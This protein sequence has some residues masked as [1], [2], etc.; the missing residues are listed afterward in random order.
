M[1]VLTVKTHPT[2]DLRL[3]LATAVTW[4]SWCVNLQNITLTV[5]HFMN[6]TCTERFE[7]SDTDIAVKFKTFFSDPTK[8]QKNVLKHS[9]C[10]QQPPLPAKMFKIALALPV[11]RISRWYMGTLPVEL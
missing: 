6:E 11:E 5:I 8:C 9:I 2:C 7:K 10:L 4:L 1:N 3:C